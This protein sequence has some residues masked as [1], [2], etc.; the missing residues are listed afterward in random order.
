MASTYEEFI[1]KLHEM[2]NGLLPAFD[3][4]P[5]S[6]IE[7]LI[8]ILS[9]PQYER[10]VGHICKLGSRSEVYEYLREH[11]ALFKLIMKG[12]MVSSALL[13]NVIKVF[14]DGMKLITRREALLALREGHA[15]GHV[16][17]MQPGV[18]W[19][20]PR[21]MIFIDGSLQDDAVVFNGKRIAENY[22]PILLGSAF[23][24][25]GGYYVVQE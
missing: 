10:I 9:D 19:S 16:A 24:S 12:G 18:Y 6:R 2:E 14:H 25:S 3:P 7:A 1:A 17:V 15:I 5:Q 23:M 20:H 8:E 21:P 13:I 22:N 4:C 11:E